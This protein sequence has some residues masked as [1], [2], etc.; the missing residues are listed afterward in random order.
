M[1]TEYHG[2]NVTGFAQQHIVRM[3]YISSSAYKYFIML[4]PGTG[5]LLNYSQTDRGPYHTPRLPGYLDL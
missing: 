5:R 1:G 4:V 2:Q 3:T